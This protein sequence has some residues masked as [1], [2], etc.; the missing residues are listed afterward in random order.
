MRAVSRRA[1]GRL[2]GTGVAAAALRP[3]FAAEVP[4]QREPVRL[5]DNENPY[6]P[7]PAAMAAMRD[8]CQRAWR[9]PDE[10]VGELIADLSRLHGLPREWFLLGDGSSEILKLAA[11]AFTGPG[12]KLVTA[13]PT[14]EA[15][16]SNARVRGVE[17]V[18]VPLDRNW[19]HDLPK[20]TMEGA[21]LVYLC[22]PN[23]PTASITPKAR[24]RAFLEAASAAVLVDEA[25]HHY[26]DSPDYQSVAPLVAS[27]PN[28]IVARTFS[29]I[30]GMAGLRLGYAIAQPALIEKLKA[31]AAWDSLNCVALAAG[32]ASLADAP[33]VAEGKKRNAATRAQVVAELERRGFASIPSQANFVMIDTRR[34]VKPLIAALH[35]RG[36]DV[37][38]LFPALP[39]HL[40]VTIGKPDQMQRFLDAFAAVT[41]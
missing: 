17:V 24:V 13:E 7:S 18:A 25:Y 36:V 30:Y 4:L 2:I 39:K 38:R 11:S 31:E 6:G 40:R 35:D 5:S 9:Y 26:V 22:N 27:R 33:W 20:M 21:G 15:I 34:E 8:A 19:G 32:R 14:F 1:L 16:A 41:S 12:R 3:L 28:L 29:K 37:G 23:N 10:A